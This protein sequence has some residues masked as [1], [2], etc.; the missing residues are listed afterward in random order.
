[1][2]QVRFLVIWWQAR[3][4]E[5][6]RDERGFTAVE[7]LLIALGVIVIAGIAVAAVKSYVTT[8]SNKL[9]QP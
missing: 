9:G 5:R 6:E 1:M 7:W 3:L 8:E 2:D 4:Y